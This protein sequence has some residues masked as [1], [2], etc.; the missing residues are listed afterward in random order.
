MIKNWNAELNRI[1]TE[2]WFRSVD[3]QAVKSWVESAYEA[4]ESRPELAEIWESPGSERSLVQLQALAKELNGFEPWSADAVPFAAAA[5]A[6]ALR[7]Y[8]AR[9]IDPSVLC[10]LVNDLDAAFLATPSPSNLEGWRGNLW[11]CCDWCGSDWTFEN[12]PHLRAEATA[13]LA[14]LEAMGRHL[15]S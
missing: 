4:G 15:L 10:R 12:T 14:R 5:L 6:M 13:V 3:P 1:A 8:L 2:C 11:N 7:R 9:E